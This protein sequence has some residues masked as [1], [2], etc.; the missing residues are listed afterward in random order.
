VPVLLLLR[1]GYL[2]NRLGTILAGII[3]LSSLFHFADLQNKSIEYA[4]VGFPAVWN[5][6]A[7]YVFAFDMAVWLAALLIA[8]GA[9]LTFVP[10]PW[11]HPLRVVMLRRT[12][13]A[14]TSLWVVAA[15][16]TLLHGFPA[17]LL[18]RIVL[19]GTAAYFIALTGLLKVRGSFHSQ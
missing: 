2:P 16:W 9:L 6:V 4:F 8:L 3:L 12:T 18:A 7:F 10:M 13:V 5:V 11:V 19:A 15:A 1:A 17:D 14:V